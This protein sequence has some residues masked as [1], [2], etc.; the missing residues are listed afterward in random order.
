MQAP[1]RSCTPTSRTRAA[2]SQRV[3]PRFVQNGQMTQA[4]ADHEIATMSAIADDYRQRLQP[5]MFA[6]AK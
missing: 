4:D 5:Q 6:E 1:K 3:Y 2:L